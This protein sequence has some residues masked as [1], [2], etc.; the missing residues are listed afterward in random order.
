V[1][2]QWLK[3][4]LG[5][6]LHMLTVAMIAGFLNDFAPSQLAEEWDNVGLLVGD[7]ARTVER[8]MTCLTLTTDSVAEAVAERADL[9]V[10]HHPLPFRPL[11]QLTTE[12]T[13]GRLLLALI[14]ARV[15]VYS[16]HTA[17]DS[18]GRGINER[19][20]AGIGLQDVSPLAPGMDDPTIGSGRWG[21]LA[22]PLRLSELT[23]RVARFLEID[24]LQFV[25]SSDR[26]VKRIAVGCGSAGDLLAAA[27]D[28]GCDCFVTGEA[29]FHACLE[30]EA[31][32]IALI[33]AG[34]FASERFAVEGLTE[35]LAV[36]FPTT[37]VWASRHERDPVRWFRLK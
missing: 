6:V 19:L 15:A 22:E 2:Y 30:A 20:A 17:F 9:V 11:K 35:M 29:R 27:L 34:H 28:R 14:E 25:G 36:Q 33:L 32:G 26:E 8:I 3:N 10:A 21:Q 23:E 16:P 5:I 18:T 12:S 13:E 1:F 7:P 24:S 37:A 31:N 4:K